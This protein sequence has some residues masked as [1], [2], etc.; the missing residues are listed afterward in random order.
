MF[1]HNWNVGA[2]HRAREAAL[3]ERSETRLGSAKRCV[4]LSCSHEQIP[5]EIKEKKEKGKLQN[6]PIHKASTEPEIAIKYIARTD[7]ATPV[8]KRT[9]GLDLSSLINLTSIN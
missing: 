9:S 4:G 2:Q 1:V 8:R 5:L 3:A 7:Q 6:R